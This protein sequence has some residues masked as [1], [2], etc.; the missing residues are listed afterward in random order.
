MFRKYLAMLRANWQGT[1]EYR[2]S[3]LIWMLSATS[4]LVSLAVWLSIAADGPV[5]NYAS[6]DFV[7]YFLAVIFVRQMSS[8]WV[9]YELDYQIRQ[10]TL[11]TKLLKPINPIHDS[12]AMNLADKV[13]R[14]PIVFIPV[15]AAALL[16]PGVHFDLGGLNILAFAVSVLLAWAQ[17]FLSQYCI[18]LLGFWV[19]HSMAINDWWFV[20]RSLLSGNLAPLDLF[21]E[22]IPALSPYLPFRY[23][24]S[25]SV[26]II[27][28]RLSGAQIWIGF[29]VQ[30]FWLLAFIALYALLWQRGLKRYSAVGA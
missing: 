1:L 9:V 30:I 15:A 12:I 11:S 27:L 7:A 26:E 3:L 22:P 24:L 28:G 4:P 2:A 10:G 18:G 20:V 25:F 17:V 21:P 23:T 29:G 16:V 14:L 19:T 8:A 13:F 5:G 6:V